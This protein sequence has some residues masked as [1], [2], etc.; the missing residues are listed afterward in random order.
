MRE[1]A[2][3]FATAA[4]V[5]LDSVP[6][7]PGTVTDQGPRYAL[8]PRMNAS[9]R[10][11]HETLRSGGRV[12]WLREPLAVGGGI[13]W[14]AGTPVLAGV[15][16][17]R[18]RVDRWAAEWG[19]HAV[20]VGEGGAAPAMNR[21]RVGL[22]KP[23]TA[24]MDEGWTRWV[25]ERWGVPF[26]TVKDARIRGG[27]LAAN[28]DAIVV[29]DISY[30]EMTRG[31]DPARSPAEYAG[32]LG[33]PGIAALRAFVEAGGTLVLLDRSTEFA[34]RDLGVPVRDIAAAQDTA[35]VARWFVPGSLLRVR[36]DTTHPLAWGMPEEG[37]VFYARSPVWEVEP[38]ARNVR[39]VARYPERGLLL[40]GYAQGEERVAGR[41]ALVEA[42]VGRG[43]VVMFGFRP[44]H[45]AQ[46][47][48]TFKPLFNA[49]YR[50]ATVR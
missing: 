33:A 7:R 28:F 6:V 21:L 47:H 9:H 44:Q 20:G 25:F 31:L 42:Q 40:S 36:W 29:P 32:G 26:D 4:L 24:S 16:D 30:R 8:D 46:P 2:R 49:L 35:D 43:R 41:A 39:V 19:V 15:P 23:W 12:T 5:R 37:A 1:V 22:Y 18:G 38:G 17:L 45:R 50:G 11:I 14:P 13:S 27:N 10:A 48:A 3:A 34:I